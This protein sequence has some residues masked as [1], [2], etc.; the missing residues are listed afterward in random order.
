MKKRLNIS[1]AGLALVAAMASPAQ[2][3]DNQDATLLITGGVT[4]SNEDNAG[5]EGVV[6]AHNVVDPLYGNI[7][8]F[9]G[10]ID[11]FYGNILPFYGN[12]GAF[13]GDIL[14]FYGN[15]SPFYG[16]I[17]P[18][19]GNISPFYGDIT[20]FWGN[21]GA[22]WGNIGAFDAANL[23]SIGD[24]WSD[25]GA[26]IQSTNDHWAAL[27]A[28][29]ASPDHYTKVYAQLQELIAQSEAQWGAAVTEQTG[30]SFEDAFVAAIFARHGIIPNDPSSLS[31]LTG[32]QRSAFF[33]DWHDTL[34]TYS[35]LDHVDHWMS[36][37][38]WTPAITQI[39]GSK[40]QSTV[41]LLDSTLQGSLLSSNVVYSGGTAETLDG[42]G[43][44]VASL[45][46]GAHDGEGV[47]GIA[48]NAKI[49][50]YNPFDVDGTASWADVADGIVALKAGGLS[51]LN[52]IDGASVI[53]MSL[54]EAGWVV[55]PGIVDVFSDRRVAQHAND[56]VYVL[57][58][59][60]DG[61][62]QTTDIEWDFSSD[63]TMILVGSVN[64]HGEVSAFSNQPGHA[65][66]L[67]N[68]VCHEAN[69]LYMRTIMAPGELMLVSDG[70]GGVVRRS[71]TSFAT[72]LVSGAITLLHDRWAWLADNPD[73][74]AEIIF[75][76]ARDL[77][78]PGPDEV[79]GWGMLDVLASQSPLD[80][81]SMTF[82]IYQYKGR[83][84]KSS[85]RSAST[86]LSDGVGGL[87]SWY[88]SNNVFFSMIEY[89]GDTHRDFV[90]PMSTATYGKR[91]NVLGSWEYFQDFVSGRFTNWILSGGTDSEGDGHAG[92]SDIR[93]TNAT[94]PGGWSMRYDSAMP[95]FNSDGSVESTHMA[96]TLTDPAGKLSFTLGYGQGAQALAGNG[97]G[98][99]S[100]YDRHHGGV[101]PV[102]GFASGENFAA[103]GYQLSA[104]TKITLGYTDNRLE[105]DEI[106]GLT[107]RERLVMERLEDH[108]AHAFTADIE[109]RVNDDL[110]VGL[111]YTHL[112]EDEAL[113]GVQ[114]TVDLLL[115]T[116]SS[117][118]ALTASLAADVGHG[119]RLDL[120]ATGARTDSHDG[121]AFRT[122]N[123]VW[124]TAG[125]LAV[126][127][128]GLLGD[129][130]RLRLAVSQPLT[131]ENG[132]IEFTQLAVIDRQT[133]ELGEW[134]QSFS[135][136]NKRRLVG[137]M[138]Y[139]TPL[140]DD[141]DLSLFG[142]YQ[143]E[144]NPG[145]TEN[146]VLGASFSLN[147]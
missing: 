24:F 71:G 50:V 11:P 102:L 19:Y 104:D 62:T 25:A 95:R 9:Y 73:A 99:F 52:L 67:D 92:F 6:V 140:S 18:F 59:G 69:R 16:N 13:W 107:E 88:E 87:P 31:A 82:T 147:F 112:R 127:K 35:G 141:A 28:A 38:N 126:T 130:D 101:N 123:G 46:A 77:G 86:I 7:D 78:A 45:I 113:L 75:R 138:L 91:T 36:A 119:I 83:G 72:P 131:V 23:A 27:E 93:S 10:N 125:Q 114:S 128:N 145:E 139:A 64:P 29:G 58:A 117:T 121:Q 80:F 118:E 43:A 17:D 20:A 84:Y 144:G 108:T 143:T 4:L 96:T 103:M 142:R 49:R 105:G 37:V 21:I 55:A 132:D 44:A 129:D 135:I 110:T 90:V 33:L 89:V 30:Q 51:L 81:N 76:S 60:N 8:P 32:L 22:F 74:T 57:A 53:N 15:I 63:P 136:E 41:G 42:H 14:P 47:M 66:L 56:T 122:G 106:Q 98:L 2:A 79:Y 26:L 100:D 68:G 39:Q 65:C 5:D 134:T 137:E 109:H 94:I 85:S 3:Q 1:A 70:E 124:S 12:I 34:M 48:P 111:Q 116:G 120:S 61:I 115:G 133:G 146:Y 97:N 54:G 40:G